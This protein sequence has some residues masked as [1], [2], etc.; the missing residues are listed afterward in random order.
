MIPLKHNY[1]L[2]YIFLLSCHRVNQPQKIKMSPSRPLTSQ[3]TYLKS[4]TLTWRSTCRFPTRVGGR[5]QPHLSG[6]AHFSAFVV[7]VPHW[8]WKVLWPHCCACALC[9]GQ[10]SVR[11]LQR[12]A[13]KGRRPSPLP[14]PGRLQE[15]EGADL[16]PPSAGIRRPTL[17]WANGGVNVYVR[18][19]VTS[20]G[21]MSECWSSGLFIQAQEAQVEDFPEKKRISWKNN[22]HVLS[23]LSVCI[24]T[25]SCWV[26]R[27]MQST[28]FTPMSDSIKF[29][30]A[31]FLFLFF[32]TDSASW[33]IIVNRRR[34]L[35]RLRLLKCL[36][37][38]GLQIW[39]DMIGP[40]CPHTNF[41]RKQNI[42]SSDHRSPLLH[43][44]DF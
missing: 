18:A 32:W 25:L 30:F 14:Q 44:P 15:E 16:K 29:F 10:V 12:A 33:I 22:V 17:A 26:V 42:T 37:M 35:R 40:E 13:G 31:V 24:I 28:C 5:S 21:F 39:P 6:P 27:V 38:T 20:R 19:S 36:Y 4:T 43:H 2:S 9:R 7:N 8:P 41:Y 1:C 23:F 3:R 11:E 34:Y